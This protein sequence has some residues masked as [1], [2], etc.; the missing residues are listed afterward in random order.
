MNQDVSM[1]SLVE[2]YAWA[3][4][5]VVSGALNTIIN[6]RGNKFTTNVNSSPTLTN[7]EIIG[8]I[9]VENDLVV[10]SG[11]GPTTN[12]GNYTTSEIGVFS[13]ATETYTVVAG[14]QQYN[15]T[16]AFNRNFPITGVFKKNFK[17]QILICFRDD[18]NKPKILNINTV[19]SP[20][21]IAVNDA[22]DMLLF[23]EANVSNIE[24]KVTT[25]G[26]LEAGVYY[27]TYN[28]ENDDKSVTSYLNLSNLV[29]V[30]ANSANDFDNYVGTESGKQ[31]DKQLAVTFDKLDTRFKFINLVLISKIKGVTSAKV[32]RKAIITGAKM[33]VNITG[34]ETTQDIT[35][36]E[37]LIKSAYYETAHT[38]TVFRQQLFLANLTTNDEL[39]YQ[40][41][42]NNIVINWTSKLHYANNLYD[43]HK[44]NNNR[45]FMHGEVYAFYIRF[46]L[47]NGSYTRAYHI[48]GRPKQNSDFQDTISDLIT[49]FNDS[50]FTD[51]L[52]IP[53]WKTEDTVA[54]SSPVVIDGETVNVGQMGYW[55]NA[56]E[57]YP[58]T[59]NNEFPTGAVRHHRFPS[60]GWCRDN[61]YSNLSEYGKNWLD[62]LGIA[63][64]NVALPEGVQGYEIMYAKRTLNNS[65]VIG[66]DLLQQAGA[67][68]SAELFSYTNQTSN[69][70]PKPIPNAGNWKT[71]YRNTA[72]VGN[73]TFTIFLNPAYFRLHNFDLLLNKP[74]LINPYISKELYLV[75]RNL[76]ALFSVNTTGIN[77][78][79]IING[80]EGGAV[81]KSGN[82][83]SKSTL[84]AGVVDFTSNNT[85][86]YNY[87]YL[88][89]D[90]SSRYRRLQNVEYTPNNT[91][92]TEWS[93]IYGQEC[94]LARVLGGR[95]PAYFWHGVYPSEILTHSPNT[96]NYFGNNDDD[97][98]IWN[99][100]KDF[101]F[102]GTK[103]Q[104]TEHT[105]LIS[106]RQLLSEIYVPFGAQELV[107]VGRI[108]YNNNFGQ[109]NY[110]WGGD[111]F[112]GYN[113]WVETAGENALQNKGTPIKKTGVIMYKRHLG[114]FI[115]NPGLRYAGGTAQETLYPKT[116]AYPS[117]FESMDLSTSLNAWNLYNKDYT[118]LNDLSAAEVYN[119][120]N[121]YVTKFPFRII[122]SKVSGEE[123]KGIGWKTFLANDYYEMAKDKGYIENIE[124]FG[125]R[126]VI[127]HQFALFLTRDVAK[128]KTDILD[129]TLG[130]GDIFD[131]PP[132]EIIPDVGYAGTHNQLACVITKIGYV[133][134]EITQGKIFVLSTELQEISS[135]GMRRFFE[136]E[137]ALKQ[138]KLTSKV[139][140][141]PFTS[142]CINGKLALFIPKVKDKADTIPTANTQYVIEYDIEG[143]VNGIGTIGY[144]TT[145]PEITNTQAA[146]YVNRSHYILYTTADFNAA[147]ASG[148]QISGYIYMVCYYKDT[149]IDYSD[150]PYIGKGITIAYDEQFNRLIV[151]KNNKGNNVVRASSRFRGRITQRSLLCEWEEGDLVVLSPTVVNGLPEYKELKLSGKYRPQD[152]QLYVA[153]NPTE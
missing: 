90:N 7:K 91:E 9:Q 123:D 147:P 58:A 55:E 128:L 63:V 148:R 72:G 57:L 2:S 22:N 53:K 64:S 26:S 111:S 3:K 107:S 106:I 79:S 130:S 65:T 133:F 121:E 94:G 136:K 34:A 78:E 118:S 139:L 141:I 71:I 114:E 88:P 46:V 30:V 131:V 70:P 27:V 20:E 74:A 119:P 87:R 68:V 105:C 142:K 77:I 145:V 47:K 135:K 11:I 124:A 73:A 8:L 85:T 115:S 43:S 13:S 25:G 103:S 117:L 76:N 35:L 42:A 38:L 39:K 89:S 81:I 95:N 67:R 21:L 144:V 19:S 146:V 140:K 150:N 29:W 80:K 116:L 112:I 33:T 108:V 151:S 41:S 51:V 82:Q 137:L 86:V 109:T 49:R 134:P 110:L 24:V 12:N 127:H 84:S 113:S 138:T 153:D 10:F 44:S 45:G 18:K 54:N 132:E 31:S 5:I 59:P 101:P 102:N 32:I 75:K 98:A 4:N 61:L 15:N 122:R 92:T 125:Y 52:Q 83:F 1:Q 99:N 60:I 36:E 62:V 126:L 6:E 129:A 104:G 152:V 56:T 16:L 48:P 66:T 100:W 97:G 14:I 120:Y 93:N 143:V 17:N 50:G 96:R 23:P 149:V 69:T 28:Y 40:Q 37:V